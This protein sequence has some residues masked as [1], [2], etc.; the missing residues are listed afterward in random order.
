MITY[1]AQR[2]FVSLKGVACN[3]SVLPTALSV[4]LPKFR[5]W[6]KRSYYIEINLSFC[7]AK[8]MVILVSELMPWYRVDS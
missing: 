8:N 4:S 3:N 6:A 1:A 2:W 5:A 7:D